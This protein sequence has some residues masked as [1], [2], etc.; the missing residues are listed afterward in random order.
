MHLPGLLKHE[1][2]FTKKMT[3]AANV[4]DISWEPTMSVVSQVATTTLHVLYALL[5]HH[6][7]KG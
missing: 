7:G 4:N 2:L 6:L 3:D 1:T 5:G